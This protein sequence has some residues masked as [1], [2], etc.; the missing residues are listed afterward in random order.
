MSKSDFHF[1]YFFSL[2]KWAVGHI[3]ICTFSQT[4]SIQKFDFI[5]AHFK[6][7]HTHFPPCRKIKVDSHIS[8]L[9]SVCGSFASSLDGVPCRVACEGK[10]PL[11]SP[12]GGR[13]SPPKCRQKRG[14]KFSF[15]ITKLSQKGERYLC[16]SEIKILT[17]V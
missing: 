10:S 8:K 15:H 2:R 6:N 3:E 12:L 13:L 4:E 1:R 16:E 9:F 14:G 7:C 5:A 17:Y 11:Q